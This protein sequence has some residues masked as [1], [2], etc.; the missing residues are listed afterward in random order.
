MLKKLFIFKKDAFRGIVVAAL[1]MA[2]MSFSEAKTPAEI[3]RT[4]HPIKSSGD[5][6]TSAA[7]SHGEEKRKNDVKEN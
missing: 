4:G 1:F 7:F 5:D 6:R 2:Y 3:A